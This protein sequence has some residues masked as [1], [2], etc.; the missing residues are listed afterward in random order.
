M[1]EIKVM[2][3]SSG[4]VMLPLGRLLVVRI[5]VALKRPVSL[6]FQ[7]EALLMAT[8][9]LMPLKNLKT[10]SLVELLVVVLFSWEEKLLDGVVFQRKA[11][12]D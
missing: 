5:V 8:I 12:L 1:A 6:I 7:E 2:E 9:G 11:A 10:S 4:Q 3:V